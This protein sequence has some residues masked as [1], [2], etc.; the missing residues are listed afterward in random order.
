MKMVKPT[1]D[2]YS[3][4]YLDNCTYV[5]YAEVYSGSKRWCVCGMY[6]FLTG[7]RLYGVTKEELNG[8]LVQ[9]DKRRLAIVVIGDTS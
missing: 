5:K 6:A 1:H 3:L 2:R 8:T 9:Y 4:S 7:T